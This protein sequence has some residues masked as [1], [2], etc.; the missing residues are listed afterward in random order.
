M[1][2]ELMWSALLISAI[3]FLGYNIKAVINTI[4]NHFISV[5]CY[6]IKVEESSEFFY[7]LQNYII[8]EKRNKIHNFY[9]KTF[10]DTYISEENENDVFYN[11]GLLWLKFNGSKIL[12][13]KDTEKINNALSTYKT[14][15]QTIFLYSFKLS[16]IDAFVKYV[17]ENYGTNKIRYYFNDKGEVKLLSD[18]PNKTFKNIFLNDDLN[19]IIQHDLDNFKNSK[20]KYNMLGLKY[21]RVYLFYGEAGTG[22][23]SLS[24][25]ISNYTKRNILSINM[26]KDMDDS[27]LI[28]LVANRPK[29]SIIQFE[30]IDCLFEDLERD[31]K[32]KDDE[33]N[34]SKGITLSCVL[35]ILDGCY[36]PND[37][38]FIITTNHIDKLD[39][40][41]KRDGRSDLMLNI[42]KPNEETK[43]KYIEYL[44]QMGDFNINLEDYKDKTI[45]SIE[46][47]FFK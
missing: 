24:T 43:K 27:V 41:I 42:T 3:G 33:K 21:K 26:S 25:A 16:S 20:F 4:Y 40:A 9:Y 47:E 19:D 35:N 39:D 8:K 38:I 14:T 17:N 22:K 5:F 36:T 6:S 2:K 28:S 37:V 18:I 31:K 12:L 13:Y 34:K 32:G 23:S 11:Y 1:T 10:F 7:Y 44:N 29:N 46:K 45:S 30:D 15:K